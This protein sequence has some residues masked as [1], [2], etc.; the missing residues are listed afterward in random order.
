V[1]NSPDQPSAAIEESF[2]LPPFDERAARRAIWRG[3][4]RTA[5]TGLL[6]VF[7]GWVI[8]T[9][10]TGLWQKRG[11]REERFQTVLGLGFLVAHPDWRGEPS[12]CCNTD[13]TSI[14]LALDVQPQT[15]ESLSPTTKAWLRLNILGRLVIDSIPT[16]PE[17]PIEQALS[18]G[19]PSKAQ[20]QALLAELPEPIRASAVVELTT[21]LGAPEFAELLQPAGVPSLSSSP[22]IFLES[23]YPPF[24]TDRAMP[25]I[26]PPRKLAWPNPQIASSAAGEG[27]L[28]A[29]D[30]LTQFKAW[31]A[32]LRDGDDRNLGRL[33]LPPAAK[34]KTLAADPKVHAFILAKASVERLRALLDDPAVRSVNV[35]DVAFDLGHPDIE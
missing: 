9:L 32:M 24:A 34:I 8:L 15:A 30:P 21:P 13:L 12:G 27:Q 33:G 20:T 26:G 25:E 14:E 35:A 5:L 18:S 6:L 1:S 3:V 29:S 11:D 19:R 7:A 31:A 28:E 17:T 4:V 16:L 2:Q 10:I 22:P 23:P